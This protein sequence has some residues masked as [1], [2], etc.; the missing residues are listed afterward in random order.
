VAHDAELQA[1]TLLPSAFVFPFSDSG[2]SEKMHGACRFVGQHMPTR[3]AA[4][5]TLM[6]IEMICCLSSTLDKIHYVVELFRTVFSGEVLRKSEAG[7]VA[8]I[9][10]FARPARARLKESPSV[11]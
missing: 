3:I 4:W 10:A 5:R 1:L 2:G 11:S 9:L 8:L 6:L 7:V